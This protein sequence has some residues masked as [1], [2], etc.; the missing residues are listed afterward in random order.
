MEQYQ[1]ELEEGLECDVISYW[2][3][4][5]YP[6]EYFYDTEYHLTSEGA[7]VRTR[8]LISDLKAWQNTENN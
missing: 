7:D 5:T 4:Y 1:G 6:K 8:Q 2:K 3:D